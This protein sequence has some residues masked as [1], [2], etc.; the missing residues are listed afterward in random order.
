MPD[1]RIALG[2]GAVATSSTTKRRWVRDGRTLHHL[3]DPRDGRP[4]R[5]VWSRSRSSPVPPA[6]AEVLTKAAFV[7]GVDAAADVARSGRSHG[8]APHRR[9]DGGAARGRR[10]VP[11]MSAQLWW[12]TAR[13]GGLVA[14][15]L[16]TASVV[17]GLLLSGRLTARRPKPAWV[18]DLHRFLG[19]LTV[20]FV[21]VH[22]L[23]LWLDSFVH[24]GAAELFV[25][26]ASGWK[27]GAVAWGIVALYLLLAVEVTSLLQRRIPRRWWH[28]VHLTSFGLFGFATV[29]ALTAGT[30]AGTTPVV[31]FALFGTLLV[32][33]NLT[34]LRVVSRRVGRAPAR[35]SGGSSDA[36]RCGSP[37]TGW[38]KPSVAAC[39][40]GRSTS[41]PDRSPP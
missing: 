2:D 18:L 11:A 24:F 30:D 23:A 14:W 40:N 34:V 26:L 5:R 29:H 39:R 35:R 6:T 3:I 21:G 37:V 27:P 32:A 12:Y 19:G 25:P 31:W 1:V 36:K 28:A 7:A 16:A 8:P 9:R 22:V 10:A 17:W 15:A 38:A 20:V 41:R 4:P 13:A 33:V